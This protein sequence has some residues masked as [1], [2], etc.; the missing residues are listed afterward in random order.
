M[1]SSNPNLRPA[2]T[3]AIFGEVLADIFPD[4]RVLGGAPFNVAR[5][6]RAFGRHPVLISRTGSDALRDAL[7]QEMAHR[8]M[9]ISGIQRDADYPTGQV[10]VIIENG[11]H[12]F[13]IL[14]D[15]AYD[16]ICEESTGEIVGSL[17]P[18]L[19]YFGTLA[20]RGAPSRRAAARFLANCHCPIFL[21]LNL[22][23]PWY[24]KAT[25]AHALAAADIVK[26]NDEELAVAAGLFGFEDLPPEGQAMALQQHFSL[27]QLLV[28]CGAAGSWLLTARQQI[29][30]AAPTGSTHPIIDTVGAGD[31][32]AAVF[33]LGLLH[34]WEAPTT[35]HRAGEYA[36]AIC[37][38]RGA[39]PPSAD[40]CDL[41][42]QDGRRIE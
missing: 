21:D 15:Q 14:P 10:R 11:S 32:F 26:L 5:H 33:M 1:T 22:R 13:D 42:G 19:A 38:R 37:S 17:Q 39:A 34:Q 25:I 2:A 12:H 41:I 9:D 28:T 31:A 4:Q 36:A 3:I 23:A 16:H 30:K 24:D 40:L 18:Q 29:L 7:L 6:L 8:D 35:L 27:E 20:Q